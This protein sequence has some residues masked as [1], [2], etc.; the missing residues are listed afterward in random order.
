LSRTRVQLREPRL[1]FTASSSQPLYLASRQQHLVLL[2]PVVFAAL[3]DLFLYNFTFC[4]YMSLQDSSLLSAPPPL[5]AIFS[6]RVVPRVRVRTL[7]ASFA[8]TT[9][10]PPSYPRSRNSA[11]S[12]RFS[13]AMGMNAF[14][15]FRRKGRDQPLNSVPAST[16]STNDTPYSQFA[17]HARSHRA[18]TTLAATSLAVALGLF[19]HLAG[20]PIQTAQNED[21]PVV[22]PFEPLLVNCSQIVYRELRVSAEIPRRPSRW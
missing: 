17:S 7:P 16:V 4:S 2:W 15:I 12:P 3:C 22:S 20:W 14:K 10:P 8:H 13:R 9:C 5:H 18:L 6:A 1:A 19:V 21:S 11:I